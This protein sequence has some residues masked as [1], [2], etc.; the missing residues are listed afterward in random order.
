MKILCL[1][2]LLSGCVA[3]P[4]TPQ[5]ILGPQYTSI[6]D[7]V[8]RQDEIYTIQRDMEAQRAQQAHDAFQNALYP[9][10]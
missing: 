6:A 2:I 4:Y 1:T 5:P 8:N 9:E 7:E 3:A 10:N